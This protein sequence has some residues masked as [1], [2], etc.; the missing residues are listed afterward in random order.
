MNYRGTIGF[1]T[2]KQL[3]L[4]EFARDFECKSIF[5]ARFLLGICDLT[6]ALWLGDIMSGLQ[7]VRLFA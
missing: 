4:G 1:D 5:M 3:T 6:Q 7:P 2:L